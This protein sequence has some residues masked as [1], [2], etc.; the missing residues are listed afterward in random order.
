M[1]I[2]VVTTIVC[3]RSKVAVF[4]MIMAMLTYLFSLGS[5]LLVGNHNTGIG[6]P[7]GLFHRIGLINLL[8]PVRFS[9][10]VALFA[11]ILL[12]LCVDR[13]YGWSGWPP[14]LWLRTAG[15]SVIAAAALIPLIPA[16]PYQMADVDTPSFFTSSAVNVTPSEF[17]GDYLSHDDHRGRRCTSLAGIRGHALQ[18]AVVLWLHTYPSDRRS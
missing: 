2:M 17:C 10:Y 5:P 14:D 16:L 13:V 7:G 1:L 4:A 12:A 11:A 3:R 9:L 15:A 6:L 8:L 18:D